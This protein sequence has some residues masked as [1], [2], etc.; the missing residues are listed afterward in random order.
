MK[1]QI[2]E[3]GTNWT[4]IARNL[5]NTPFSDKSCYD[6]F[7]F[8]TIRNK[9][10]TLGELKLNHKPFR[11]NSDRVLLEKQI[12]WTDELVSSVLWMSIKVS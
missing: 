3:N 4:K 2:L 5:P 7:R 8:K 1:K 6:R 9:E 12:S 10:W 11:I